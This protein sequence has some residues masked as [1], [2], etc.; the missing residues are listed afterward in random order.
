MKRFIISIIFSAL[1][2]ANS[3]CGALLNKYN[4]DIN[5][6]SNIGWRR[7]CYNGLLGLYTNK[8]LNAKD[9]N[10]I[11]DNCFNGIDVEIGSTLRRKK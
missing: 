10:Y 8:N 9:E 7:V 3:E 2:N 1:L 5:I 6:H 4:I 11:C